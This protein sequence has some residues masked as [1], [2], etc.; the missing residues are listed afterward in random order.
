VVDPCLAQYEI[1]Q[2]EAQ[3]RG[4]D[5]YLQSMQIVYAIK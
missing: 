4:Y 2:S 1:P 5:S 3:Q